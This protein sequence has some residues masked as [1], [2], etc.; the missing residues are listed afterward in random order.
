MKICENCNKE[1]KHLI[2]M[3]LDWLNYNYICIPCWEEIMEVDD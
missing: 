1:V 3:D 2:N